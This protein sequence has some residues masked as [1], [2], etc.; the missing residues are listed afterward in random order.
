MNISLRGKAAIV[1]GAA[2]GIGSASAAAFVEAG[3]TVL[4]AD[5]NP[6]V[7]SVA[8]SL[9]SAAKHCVV[10]VSNEEAVR[11]LVDQA[12]ADF[13]RLDIMFAN[14]GIFG[15]PRDIFTADVEEWTRVF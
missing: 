7:R 13:G 14:A 2:S 6:V 3:A 4:L 1:T 11:G 15:S 12:V 5:Q 9:G 10:D 8:E